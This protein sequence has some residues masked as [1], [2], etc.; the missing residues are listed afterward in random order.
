[1]AKKVELGDIVAI[2]WQD[3]ESICDIEL[4]MAVLLETLCFATYGKYVAETEDYHYIAT[5]YNS[6]DHHNNDLLR[7]LK[8]STWEIKVLE[9]GVL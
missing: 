5:T 2:T 7:I 4:K 3:H 9:K 8:A 6:E 1:M